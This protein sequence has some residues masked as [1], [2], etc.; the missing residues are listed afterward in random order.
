MKQSQL[1]ELSMLRSVPWDEIR[2]VP[3][4]ERTIKW[5][6]DNLD[7]RRGRTIGGTFI[8]INN[9]VFML[10]ELTSGDETSLRLR[11]RLKEEYEKRS[12]KEDSVSVSVDDIDGTF[13]KCKERGLK[14]VTEFDFFDL[15]LKAYSFTIEDCDGYGVTF[16]QP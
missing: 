10:W 9:T 5:Y 2:G 12:A 16:Y 13:K 6:C 11:E 14:I 1:L 7:A 3:N 8:K 15:N 4:L